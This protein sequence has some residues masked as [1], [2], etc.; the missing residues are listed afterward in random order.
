VRFDAN[1]DSEAASLYVNQKWRAGQRISQSNGIAFC[2]RFPVF[3]RLLPQLSYRGAVLEI[4]RRFVRSIPHTRHSRQAT[5]FGSGELYRRPVRIP[6][7][8]LDSRPIARCG[9]TQ[10][11]KTEPPGKS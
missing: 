3:I 7:P 9:Q 4:C 6:V 5:S 8:K 10:D 11:N 2:N 1:P